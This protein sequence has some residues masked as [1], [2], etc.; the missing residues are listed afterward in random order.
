MNIKQRWVLIA[1]AVLV[2]A[3]FF[4]PPVVIPI[5]N[6]SFQYLKYKFLLSLDSPFSYGTVNVQLLLA[7]WIAICIL[8]GIGYILC[9]DRKPPTRP[10]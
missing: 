2:I 9:S 4:F 10:N 8:G 5:A 3:T 6:T 7:E 1:V